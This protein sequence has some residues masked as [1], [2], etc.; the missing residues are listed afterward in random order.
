MSVLVKRAMDSL[1]TG[2]E[3]PAGES[4]SSVQS[5]LH[6]VQ[7]M[8]DRLLVCIFI[9]LEIESYGMPTSSV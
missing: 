5:E 4:D 9:D 1:N 7:N 8:L 2:V 3:S 6:L